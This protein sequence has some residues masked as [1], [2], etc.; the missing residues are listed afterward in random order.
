[1]FHKYVSHRLSTDWLW[2]R[3]NKSANNLSVLSHKE[4]Y[5]NP[6]RASSSVNHPLFSHSYF[7]NNS[8]FS[9]NR[10]ESAM[11]TASNKESIVKK[12]GFNSAKGE[13]V[14]EKSAE[15]VQD[16]RTFVQDI[17]SLIK[18]TADLSGE[19]LE[20]AKAKLGERISVAKKTL[21]GFGETISDRAG[22]TV[23]AANE[24]VHEKPWPVIGASAAVGFL[25]AYLLTRRE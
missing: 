15:L 23:T 22:K 7:F 12:F 10:E 24:Y 20:K 2:H 19:D 21:E 14:Q 8:H 1:M 6:F 13:A 17:E 5:D 9:N 25:A 11:Q 3:N 4:L 16:F 18:S